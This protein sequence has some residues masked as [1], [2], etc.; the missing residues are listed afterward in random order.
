MNWLPVLLLAVVM[1]SFLLGRYEERARNEE[2]IELEALRRIH[3]AGD[4]PAY[5]TNKEKV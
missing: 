3:R 1:G 5:P 4:G 2:Q